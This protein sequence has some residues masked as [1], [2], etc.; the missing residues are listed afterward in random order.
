MLHFPLPPSAADRVVAN[1]AARHINPLIQTVGRAATWAADE[2]VFGAITAAAWV[3][4]RAG[5]ARQRAV[6]NHMAITL[7]ASVITPKMIKKVVDRTR[8]D[9]LVDGQH[10]HGVKKSGNPPTPSLLDIV[11]RS[12]QS[13][14]P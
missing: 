6:A 13:S 12:E 3:L 4:S 10:G 5:T 8:P 11:F 2:H 7:A 1:A 14:P 9:R